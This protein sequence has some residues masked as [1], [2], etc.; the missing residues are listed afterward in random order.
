MTKIIKKNYEVVIVGAGP[1]GTT[2]ANI[3]G[4]YNIDTL[5]ID[6]EPD[7][8]NIPRAVGMCEEGSRIMDLVGVLDDPI[9]DFRLINKIHFLDKNQDSLFHAD[10]Y[11]PNNGYSIIRT[12]HQPDLEKS[13]RRAMDG[14]DC[15]Q[16][17]TSTEL[18]DFNDKGEGVELTIK[19]GDETSVIH[20]QYLLACDGAS[21]PVRKKLNISFEG[22]TYPQD[23]MIIDIEN[24]PVLS[25]EGAFTINPERPSITLPGPGK[26]RRWE[27]VVKE[28]DDPEMLFKPENLQELLKGWGDIE[29][30]Q[31]SRKAVYT[32]HARTAGQY[33][34]NNVFLLGDAAHITPPFAGQGMMAGMRDAH[35]LAW[36][37]SAVLKNQLKPKVLE[38]YQSERLPQSYQVIKFAQYIGGVVLPQN[39]LVAGIRNSIIRLLGL[40]GVHSETKGM[41][42]DKVHNHINGNYIKC[43]II[44][45]IFNTGV[46]FPQHKLVKDNKKLLSDKLISEDFHII[47]MN[48]NPAHYLTEKTLSRWRS[49]L[50]K[51]TII[52]DD[53]NKP[54]Q[55]ELLLDE[56]G[57]YKKLF[58]SGKN[59]VVVRP[60]KMMVLHC[61]IKNLDKKLNKYMDAVGCTLS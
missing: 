49:M 10:T 35:N 1:C 39:N 61:T 33:R 23:W 4:K 40:L 31:V 6:K 3:L 51:E 57:Q 22:D 37:L 28:H 15:V 29:D 38:T 8:V 54:E 43:R 60:D 44:S 48:I 30:L 27:F 50:G 34:A 42:L 14:H 16:L 12:F 13:L 26:R 9:M 46:E 21:S 7:I 47:G 11:E 45:K 24:S 59:L 2:A 53:K 5:V 41:P 19:Q 32:F 52:T 20:C 18:I 25:S 17:L 55:E 36:K 58:K 56:K